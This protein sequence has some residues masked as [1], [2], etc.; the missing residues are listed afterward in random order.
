MDRLV[1]TGPGKPTESWILLKHLP[2]QFLA[3][4][5]KC[6]WHTKTWV[7]TEKKK[8]NEIR[9]RE[10]EMNGWAVKR[11]EE[12]QSQWE[13][14][15]TTGRCLPL[16]FL[17]VILGTHHSL[18]PWLGSGN[19]S[20]PNPVQHCSLPN[21]KS[22]GLV[23][24]SKSNLAERSKSC[25]LLHGLHLLPPLFLPARTRAK[26]PSRGAARLRCVFKPAVTTCGHLFTTGVYTAQAAAEAPSDTP[27]MGCG[28]RGAARRVGTSPG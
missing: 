16:P 8:K 22:E 28:V 13:I 19:S 4:N 25:L 10:K 15:S 6:K 1:P 17:G 2:W 24:S 9:Y 21:W 11:R 23:P 3:K 18:C 20:G 14:V 26:E 12:N 7:H 5:H 27:V